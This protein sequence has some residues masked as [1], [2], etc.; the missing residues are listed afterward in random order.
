MTSNADN[1]QKTFKTCPIHG[2]SYVYSITDASGTRYTNGCPLCEAEK[3][4]Q[5]AFGQAL[6]PA[7]FTDQTFETYGSDERR[8]KGRC[9]PLPGL[10]EAFRG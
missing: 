2:T 9:K 8:A 4:C 3:R 7:R 5:A 1:V 10:C 6:I